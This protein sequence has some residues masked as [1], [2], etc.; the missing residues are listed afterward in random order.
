MDSTRIMVPDMLIHKE[1]KRLIL[2]RDPAITALIPHARSVGGGKYVAVP[3]NREE[4]R[5]L[6]N[7][8]HVAPSP[9]MH[10]Y[11]WPGLQV[12]FES[13]KKTA[14]LLSMNTRAYVLN[15]M[16]TGKTRASLFAADF[17]IQEN[18]IKKVEPKAELQKNPVS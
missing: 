9:I 10:A 18:E 7:L 15:T 16:G 6:R 2:E 4:T 8:G 1:S 3:H 5:L 13:Q 14:A 11:K 12:P 17:L